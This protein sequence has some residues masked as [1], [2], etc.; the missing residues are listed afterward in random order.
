MAKHTGEGQTAADIFREIPALEIQNA[1]T[2]L[3]GLELVDLVNIIWALAKAADDTIDPPE[4]WVRQFDTFPLDVI[5][6]AAVG[7]VLDS[8]ISTKNLKTLQDID[9]ITATALDYALTFDAVQAM[10][11]GQVVDF[12]VE[13]YN[14]R[15]K[16]EKAEKKGVKRKATQADIDAFLGG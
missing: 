7:L 2:E 16:A 6:P 15:K 8:S 14:R 11:L 3:A 13:K 1:I 10:T 9:S 5:L 12:C 4:V